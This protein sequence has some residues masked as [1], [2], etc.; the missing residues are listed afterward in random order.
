M[1]FSKDQA[2]S[3][4]NHAHKNVT[5]LATPVSKTAPIPGLAALLLLHPSYSR[6]NAEKAF[7]YSEMYAAATGRELERY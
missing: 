2:R 1:L 4:P 3:A 5:P 7:V 6:K